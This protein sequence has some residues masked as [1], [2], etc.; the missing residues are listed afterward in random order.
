M[1]CAN[2]RLE[3]CFYEQALALQPME[4]GHAGGVAVRSS[5]GAKASDVG[6]PPFGRLVGLV[7]KLP[8]LTFFVGPLT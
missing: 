7:A 3:K 4:R 1:T 6:K 5:I 2:S 8:S